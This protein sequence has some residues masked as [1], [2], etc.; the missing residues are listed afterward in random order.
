MKVL[1]CAASTL[2]T[3]LR[4]ALNPLWK[5]LWGSC[6]VELS[7]VKSNAFCKPDMWQPNCQYSEYMAK[8]DMPNFSVGGRVVFG[9]VAL[10]VIVAMLRMFHVF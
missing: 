1:D 10:V 5:D 4:D 6:E 3:S 8:P 9:I 2:V 7:G